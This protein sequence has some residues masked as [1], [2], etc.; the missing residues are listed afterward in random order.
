MC[1]GLGK[2]GQGLKGPDAEAEA[3]KA[4]L[5]TQALKNLLRGPRGLDVGP[6]IGEME[7]RP[8]AEGQMLGR[9]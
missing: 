7:A 4:T 2:P 1:L 3:L 6:W 8:V 5:P 9:G